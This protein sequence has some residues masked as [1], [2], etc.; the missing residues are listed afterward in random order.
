MTAVI[1]KDQ[2]VACETCIESCPAEAICMNHDKAKVIKE[3][4]V[5]CGTCVEICPSAAIH[6][7]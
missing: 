7:E 5:D 6:I 1:D 4:C 2:C 3:K